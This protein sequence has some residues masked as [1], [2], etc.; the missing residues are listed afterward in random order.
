MVI[1]GEADTLKCFCYDAAKAIEAPP[2]SQRNLNMEIH[3]ALLSKKEADR[4]DRFKTHRQ[5]MRIISK[6]AHLD[7]THE[8]VRLPYKIVFVDR[9]QRERRVRKLL[10]GG[11]EDRGN[12]ITRTV[13]LILFLRELLDAR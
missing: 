2:L 9:H 13:A 8:N 3:V 10:A 7:S 1:T 5:R 4:I 11:I 6:T 12:G